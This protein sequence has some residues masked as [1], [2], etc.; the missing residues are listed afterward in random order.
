MI[1]HCQNQ[2]YHDVSGIT[3]PPQS[4]PDNATQASH[5]G[6]SEMSHVNN[7]AADSIT[8]SCQV[9]IPMASLPVQQLP[10]QKKS[11]SIPTHK[12]SS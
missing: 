8:S 3:T 9:N 7:V 1:L 12:T 10:K 2:V 6:G 4:P 11:T 5:C